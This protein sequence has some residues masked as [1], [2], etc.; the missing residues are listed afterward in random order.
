LKASGKILVLALLSAALGA[1]SIPNA[2]AEDSIW[3]ALVLGTNEEHPKAACPELEKYWD[4]LRN[5]FGYNQYELLGQHTEA[6]NGSEDHWLIPR[7]DFLLHVNSQKSEKPG[8]FRMKLD[9][10]QEKKLLAQMEARISGRNLLFI[11][12]PNYG[13]GRIIIILMVE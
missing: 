8:F 10:Y 7:K 13:N 1:V 2:R 6:M 12:G 3:S 4:K 5:D 9:L 11:R